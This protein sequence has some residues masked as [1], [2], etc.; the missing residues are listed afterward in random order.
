MGWLSH[1]SLQQGAVLSHLKL[2]KTINSIAVNLPRRQCSPHSLRILV[3]PNAPRDICKQ[4]RQSW[5]FLCKNSLEQVTE[6]GNFFQQKWSTTPTPTKSFLLQDNPKLHGWY[7][8][9]HNSNGHREFGVMFLFSRFIFVRRELL[10]ARHMKCQILF[11]T[12]KD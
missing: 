6:T 1:R 7:L 5:D 9:Y 8:R 4:L 11:G 10:D 2:L 12:F 3:V